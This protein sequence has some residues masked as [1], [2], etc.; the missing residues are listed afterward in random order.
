MTDSARFP[1]QP[2]RHV[3]VSSQSSAFANLAQFPDTCR[4]TANKHRRLEGKQRAGIAADTR[5]KIAEL[6][7]DAKRTLS[8][9][10]SELELPYIPKQVLDC[11][12]IDHLIADKNQLDEVDPGIG[13][14]GNLSVL[15]L[16]W[17][18]IESPLPMSLW[19][20]N[21]L[22]T[23][24]LDHN[25]IDEIPGEIEKLSSLTKLRLDGNNIEVI[26]PEMGAR[27]NLKYLSLDRNNLVD[28]PLSM[29]KMVRRRRPLLARPRLRSHIPMMYGDVICGSW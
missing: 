29:K 14:M 18:R 19:E 22:R 12:F 28:L 21:C 25:Q 27:T 20:L 5:R 17:N 1:L 4:W 10:I 24:N 3:V 2:L 11:L 23:L 7:L 16:S 9:D 8:I 15:S 13:R 26:P 6:I